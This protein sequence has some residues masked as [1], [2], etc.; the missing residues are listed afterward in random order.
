MEV[1]CQLHTPAA[2]PQ[3]KST[4]YPLDRR[5]GGPQSRSGRNGDEKNS[6]PLPELEPSIIQPV[7]Q[8]CTTELSQICLRC[9]P[10]V[11]SLCLPFSPIFYIKLLSDKISS[12]CAMNDTNSFILKD[13]ITSMRNMPAFLFHQVRQ[14][15]GCSSLQSVVVHVESSGHIKTLVYDFDNSLLVH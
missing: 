15:V 8:C 11:K 7:A 5:L 10:S 2:L 3:G 6:Q 14:P 12:I 9:K 1:S 4:W 13:G